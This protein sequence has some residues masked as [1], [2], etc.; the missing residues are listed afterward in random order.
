MTPQPAAGSG[1]DRRRAGVLLHLTSLPG[2]G[3]VGDLGPDARRFVDFLAAAGLSVWQMLP[4]GP[5]QADGSP[6]QSSSMHAG[7]PRLISLQPLVDEGLLEDA[8]LERDTLSDADRQAALAA[9]WRRFRDGGGETDLA[10]D[11][12]A[13]SG[14]HAHWLE[15]YALYRAIHREQRGAGWWLWPPALRDREPQAMAQARARLADE[16]DFIR[17]EQFQ[18]FRQ[19]LALKGYANAR[20]VRLF[21]DM[22]IFVAHDSAEVWARRP[23]FLLDDEGHPRVVAGVPPDYF[24]E[25]GQRWG[26]PLYDWAYMESHGFAFWVER[27]QTQLL[28]FDLVR[29]DH[30]RGFEA[31]WEIPAADDTAINGR[32]VEA[33]GD[34]LF[35]HLHEIFDP[36][37]LVAEDLGIIT[38]E[39][40]LLRDGYGLPGMKILQF[41]FSGDPDNP[42]L[43][44]RHVANSVVYTGT[45]DNDTTL[46]WYT[47]LDDGQRRYVDE[48]FGYS[49]E[50]M[51]WPMIRSALA[52][53][54]RLAVIPM[55][56]L[57]GLDGSHRMN[58]PGTVEGNWG[59]RFDWSELDADL[60]ERLRRRV[61]MYARAA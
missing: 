41:A 13:F 49:Q 2:P 35:R 40:E 17:F 24:S 33:P 58:L 29:I 27:L 39:V 46:G 22:P 56:D 31:Y 20:G 25:T 38:P 21:G 54:A 59:W 61:A 28:L 48:F 12:A 15:E 37:P 55:Q 52:S 51:P 44:F 19:W 43:P 7:N 1:L 18:F 5:T 11:F 57:L 30:F 42:Y 53:R 50:P 3:P 4:I 26:N 47:S 16:L 36:L 23:F 10:A 9:A 60:A 8:W 32:W 14:E 45:H 6:Y 34:A